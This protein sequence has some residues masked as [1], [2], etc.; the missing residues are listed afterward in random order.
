MCTC[1][2]VCVRVRRSDESVKHIHVCTWACICIYECVRICVHG[3]V[4]VC[5]CVCVC[6]RC[7]DENPFNKECFERSRLSLHPSLAGVSVIGHIW[8]I[9]VSFG[10]HVSHLQ[11]YFRAFSSISSSF[12]R[13]SLFIGHFWH[14]RVSFGG[15]IYSCIVECSRLSLHPTLASV[16]FI[17]HFDHIWVSFGGHISYLHLYC[18]VLLLISPSFSCRCLFYRSLLTFTDL[19]WRSH[20]TFTVLLSSALAYLSTLFLRVFLFTGHFW[21]LQVSFIIF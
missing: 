7:S 6:V 8:H 2:R 18:R 10:G 12:S 11:S 5:M 3:Y 15:H 14:I 9:W 19:F 21:H 13:R 17:G 20:F 1:M 16:S 4:C